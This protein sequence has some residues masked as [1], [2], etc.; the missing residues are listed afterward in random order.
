MHLWANLGALS[1]AD[2][3]ATWDRLVK[4]LEAGWE[5]ARKANA[6]NFK[7]V[8]NLAGTDYAQWFPYGPGLAKQPLPAGEFTVEPEGDRVLKGLQT[9]GAFT[10]R[11]SDKYTGILTSPRFKIETD[12]ISVRAFGGGG[13]M[14]RVIVDNYPLPS[15][16]IFPKAILDKEEP[17]W[18]RLDTA[19]RKGSY[20]YLEFATREDLTRPLQDKKDKTAAKPDR[21]DPSWFGVEQVVLH[22][23][24]K[25][26]TDET[27][28]L[29][30]LLAAPPPRSAAELTQTY[31]RAITD[32]V[33]AWR[34]H[35][36]TEPQRLLLD[37]LVRRGILPSKLGELDS[38]RPLV[39]EYRRLE[40][41]V[42]QL[43][44]APGVLETRAYD[45]PLLPRGDHL[46]P[47]ELVP[48]GY[49]EVLGG[50]R[51][52][53]SLSGRAELADAIAN[54]QNPLTARVMVNRIWHWVFGRGI[55]ATVDNFGR[56]GEKPTHPELLDFLAARF[57]EDGWSMK[58]TIRYL[59]T[60]RAFAMSS[61]PS[62]AA[63]E[64]DPAN[65]WLSHM[66]VRRIEAESIRD[67]LLSVSGQLS[68]RMF[69]EPADINGPRRS[70]YLPVRRTFL[71]PF[72]QVFDAPKPFTTLGRRDATNVPAQSLALLNSPFV[73]D[74]AAKWA[75]TLVPDE[76]GGTTARVRKMFLAAFA[77]EPSD[78]ELAASSAYLLTLAAERK[79]R[80]D[81]VLTTPLVWQ[82]FAQSLFNLKEF[83][84]LR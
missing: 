76:T 54:P 39:A 40:A 14:V 45:A 46:H 52:Q 42:P 32:A 10:N 70:I 65:D 68:S 72:L 26:P 63:S 66:Q 71:N 27:S 62:A 69:G 58:D 43:H 41:T 1:D 19:Y 6:A 12:S 47:G 81:Q 11:L 83:I 44:H 17:G 60:T 15:N 34:S 8:W 49:L 80:A 22:N 79:V 73:I 67:A 16:P 5:D 38:V 31:R 53:T 84:Y 82:D 28:A 37:G 50:P 2:F 13:A 74:E 64:S 3:P 61:Q 30:P 57:V 51:Y 9:G 33:T 35:Q 56:M 4:P 29:A 24:N 20:A 21:D 59:V 77:R 75:Q 25:P 78:E 7:P 36:L 48:R 55:V 18:V 23:G